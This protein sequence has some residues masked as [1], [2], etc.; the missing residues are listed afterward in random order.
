MPKTEIFDRKLVL[1][2][3]TEVFHLKGYNAT[4]MQDLVDAT[5]LNRSSI[6]NSF[7]SKENLYMHCLIN[8]KNLYNS[9][10]SALVN[11]SKGAINAIATIFDFY[12]NDIV[13]DSQNKGCMLVNCKSEI[14]TKNLNILKFL[15]DHQKETLS[16]LE[17]L[18]RQG[19]E[20]SEINRKKNAQ[21][22][23]LFLFSALQGLRMT[24]ILVNDKTKLQHIK[25]TT[26][27]ILK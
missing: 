16:F 17:A 26:I 18:I 8:Y 1:D 7:E 13:K 22:Y 11:A 24:G 10:S 19:Q 27:A 21:D 9:K 2:K 12:I 15:L 3:A 25:E 14:G 5:G 23:A 20:H 4:S 6:Y